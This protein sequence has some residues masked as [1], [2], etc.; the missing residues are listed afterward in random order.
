MPK[1]AGSRM[2][3]PPAFTRLPPT[4]TTVATWNSLASSPMRVEHDDVG[5]RLGVDG[6]RGPPL[7]AVALGAHNSTT[8]SKRSGCRGATISSASGRVE[9]TRRKARSTAGSSPRSVLA[10]MS[11]VRDSRTRKKR[12]TRSR[13]AAAQSSESNF[14]LPVTTTRAGS[15]PRS[16]RRRCDSSPCAQQRSTSASTR[17]DE[18]GARAGSAETS[19]PR[20]GR[21]PARSESR[22][23][24]TRAAGSATARS[25]SSGTAAGGTT[26]STRRTTHGRSNGK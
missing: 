24:G 12:S 26:S 2:L 1:T 4:N 10:A 16:T 25:P 22:A 19:G 7:H 9:R 20:C 15:A 21:S 3:C 8:S 11:T 6:Q 14:R 5:A 23:R 13:P 17:R 18:R